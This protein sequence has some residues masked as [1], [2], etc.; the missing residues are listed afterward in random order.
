MKTTF[1]ETAAPRAYIGTYAKYNNGSLAGAWMT[2]TDYKNYDAFLAACKQ[3]HRNEPDPEFMCQDVESM[4]DGV[5]LPEDF[6]RQDFEDVLTASREEEKSLNQEETEEQTAGTGHFRIVDYSE[7]ALAVYGDTKEI[8]EQ[9]KQLGGRFNSRLRDGAGWIFSKSKADQLQA[10]LAGAPMEPVRNHAFTA[11]KVDALVPYQENLKEWI[12]LYMKEDEAY[13]LKNYYG[14]VKWTYQGKVYYHLIERESINTSFWFH[15]EGPNYDFYLKVT[16]SEKYMQD[17]F[18]ADNMNSYKDVDESRSCSFYY[19]ESRGIT[20][21][22]SWKARYELN[23]SVEEIKAHIQEINKAMAAIRLA[24]EK[25][26]H[27]YL[28][29]WGINKLRFDTYWADR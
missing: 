24:H 29:R 16:E 1:K 11:R 13:Y 21:F 12:N 22:D 27:T 7:K 8:K 6:S 3:I 10:L 2:L 25:R 18:L 5:T 15:D 23:E 4:P 28:K 26:L 9:L 17:Y 14:A 20:Y 19:D